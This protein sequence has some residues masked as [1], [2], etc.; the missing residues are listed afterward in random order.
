[1]ATLYLHIGTSK[2]GTSAI[3]VFCEENRAQLA[4]RGYCFPLLPY[5]YPHTA[6]HRN[7]R[8][9]TVPRQYPDGSFASDAEGR[10][11]RRGMARVASLFRRYPNVV[12]SDEGIWNSTGL[13]AQG[14]WKNLRRAADEFGFQVRVI[15]YLRRQDSFAFSLW[16]QKVKTN[17]GEFAKMTWEEALA[18][19][20]RWIVLDYHRHLEEIAALFGREAID[21]R[22]YDRERFPNG[23]VIEDFLNALGLPMED[24]YQLPGEDVNRS[25]GGNAL[26]IQRIINALPGVDPKKMAGVRRAV[27]A[28]F[29]KERERV[30]YSMFTGEELR[31]FLAR[32]EESNRKLARDYLGGGDASPFPPAEEPEHERWRPDNPCAVAAYRD[33]IEAY[34]AQEDDTRAKWLG[35]FLRRNLRRLRQAID[36]RGGGAEN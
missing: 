29:Q 7:A 14:M 35:R 18:V 21:V 23:N 32:Y 13:T 10:T 28:C 6:L 26:E 27:S 4:R 17:R 16:A 15:V 2:T 36:V 19:S 30:R 31:A 25:I 1:M 12:L 11:W 8:F 24:A 3:Q 34:L 33:F 22:L 9:L 5:K 20:E